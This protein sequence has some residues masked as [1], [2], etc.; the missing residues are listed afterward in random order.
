[1]ERHKLVWKKIRTPEQ[2]DNTNNQES[3]VIWDNGEVNDLRRNEHS[4]NIY[5]GC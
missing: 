2:A 1:M 3:E 5:S 4:P